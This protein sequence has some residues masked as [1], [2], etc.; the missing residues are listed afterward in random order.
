MSVFLDSCIDNLNSYV[1]PLLHLTEI[2][3]KVLYLQLDI[4]CPCYVFERVEF[5]FVSYC[6]FSREKSGTFRFLLFIIHVFYF[7]HFKIAPFSYF[8][9]SVT[10]YP[11]RICDFNLNTMC[12]RLSCIHRSCYILYFTI[13]LWILVYDRK[14]MKGWKI[15]F[16]LT[17]MPTL[18]RER[19]K[20]I[21]WIKSDTLHLPSLQTAFLVIYL[22][23]QCAISDTTSSI[24]ISKFKHCFVLIIVQRDATESSLFII[25][26]VHF[27]CFGCQ[28]HPSSRVHKTVTTAS[29]TSDVGRR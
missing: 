14:S 9:M 24:L 13:V 5:V 21:L 29:G 22:F 2:V 26:Q 10:C 4:V 15:N 20:I 18:W 6:S 3:K 23:T 12:T 16:M 17:R 27:T 11:L 1:L 7:E 19:C 25:L 28:P 8:F